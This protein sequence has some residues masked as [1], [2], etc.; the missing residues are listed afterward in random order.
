MLMFCAT[1]KYR[2][3]EF[4]ILWVKNFLFHFDLC[5]MH[6]AWNGDGCTFKHHKRQSEQFWKFDSRWAQF[7]VF[8]LTPWEC[9]SLAETLPTSCWSWIQYRWKRSIGCE[10][11]DTDVLLMTCLYIL[12]FTFLPVFIHD[13]LEWVI[14]AYAIN[15]TQCTYTRCCYAQETTNYASLLTRIVTRQMN[16]D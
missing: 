2:K 4:F 10:R 5:N 16:R 14:I 3:A 7:S 11:T 13:P 15:N 6:W 8:H 9:K 1:E 12:V